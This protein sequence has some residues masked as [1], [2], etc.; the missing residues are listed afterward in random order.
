M[1]L[2]TLAITALLLVPM[3]A[4]CGGD[5]TNAGE[6]P[7]AAALS[8]AFQEAAGGGAAE[9]QVAVFDCIAEKLHASE[10]SDGALRSIVEGDEDAKIKADNEAKYT[11]I[12]QKATTD[13]ASEAVEDAGS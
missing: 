11:E 4:A 7:S 13:C 10:I 9:G 1:R 3:G 8:K 2:R 6:R 12:F 5:D